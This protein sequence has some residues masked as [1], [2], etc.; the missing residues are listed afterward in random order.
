MATQLYQ[1]LAANWDA[2][3]ATGLT[4]TV[5]ASIQANATQLNA[6][7]SLWLIMSGVATMFGK[8]TFQ[9]WVF[10]A[11]RAAFIGIL[12]TAAGFSTWIQTPLMTTIPN[13]IAQNVNGGGMVTTGPQQFD[14]LRD[15]IVAREA[16]ILQQTSGSWSP[17]E[18]MQSLRAS[19]ATWWICLELTVSFGIWE[20]ARGM[21]G[22]IV[23][24]APFLLFFY[25]WQT[26]RHIALNIGGAALALLV[27]DVMLSVL[28]SLAVNADVAFTNQAVGGGVEVQLDSLMN[29]G[30]FFLF[31]MGMTVILPI[32]ASRVAH[33]FLPSAAP[34]I[35]PTMNTLQRAGRDLGEVAKQMRRQAETLQKALTK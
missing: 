24:T 21:M 5:Q 4:Q 29:I 8:M 13:W 28:L 9:E 15:L 11:S 16:A 18:A 22:V 1:S 30:L 33:G 31:G 2:A 3:I 34:L 10:G 12:L 32:I 20:G 27:L 7:I 25:M 19:W 6:A 17:T 14:M 23:A 35:S 26:T